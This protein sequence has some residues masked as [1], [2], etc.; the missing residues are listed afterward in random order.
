VTQPI[1]VLSNPWSLSQA[2]TATM[3]SPSGSP[4]ENDW[5]TTQAVRHD[6]IDR[7]RLW[8]VEGRFSGAEASAISAQA[9]GG[10]AP[11]QI[12]TRM[13]KR[14]RVDETGFDGQPVELTTRTCTGVPAGHITS[15]M[16]FATSFLPV[17]RFVTGA[18]TQPLPA[19][20][21]TFDPPLKPA[22]ITEA[23][24]P[25]ET[26]VAIADETV[27]GRHG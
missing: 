27:D 21:W 14:Y 4:D 6:R 18:S 12:Q 7:A 9:Y 26:T 23:L 13:A 20:I 25:V 15:V 24:T 16:F 22:P 3:T 19:L 8:N 17:L 10:C 11:G 2:G 1:V 5:S